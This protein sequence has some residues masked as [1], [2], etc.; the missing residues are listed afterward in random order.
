MRLE[1]DYYDV[2]GVA[3]GAT[4]EEIKRAFRGLARS[5]HPDVAPDAGDGRFHEVVAA[6]EVLSHPKRRRPRPSRS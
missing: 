2:L 1:H 6:Y 5:L 3:R 4:E